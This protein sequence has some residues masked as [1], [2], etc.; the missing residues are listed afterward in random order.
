[1]IGHVARLGGNCL[2]VI[3]LH[4]YRRHPSG[5]PPKGAGRAAR[6]GSRTDPR[7]ATRTAFEKLI[8]H[9]IEDA[10][11]FVVI[12]GDLYD[13]DR[14]DTKTGPSSCSRWAASRRPRSR[15]TCFTEITD[16]ENLITRKLYAKA[17]SGR[18]REACLVVAEQAL[19]DLMGKYEA[20]S[21]AVRRVLSSNTRLIAVGCAAWRC[22]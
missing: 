22:G 16:A 7:T 3:P 13:G 8:S 4:P 17:S 10:V 11:D 1:M 19:L 18:A 14:R 6:R 21:K 9:A 5:Q 12:A 2:A 20:Q 15:S